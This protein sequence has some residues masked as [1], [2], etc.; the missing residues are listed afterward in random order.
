RGNAQL[1][2]EPHG[3]LECARISIVERDHRR[4]AKRGTTNQTFDEMAQRQH[5]V[6]IREPSH[7]LREPVAGQ[8]QSRIASLLAAAGYHIV[9]AENEP[10][11]L[12][13]P[14]ERRGPQRS[15]PAVVD[16]GTDTTC[17]C[18]ER[19]VFRDDPPPGSPS[20]PRS[21]T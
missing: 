15:Q 19:H 13:A 6:M 14:S 16:G 12:N 20:A 5:L 2:E 11:V 17:W 3:M 1:L 10:G 8:V 7:L 21:R 9:V 18:R 4:R